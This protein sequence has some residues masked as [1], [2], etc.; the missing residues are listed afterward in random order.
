KSAMGIIMAVAS[1]CELM[2]LDEPYLGLDVEKRQVFYDVLREEH[3]RTIVISTHHLN[4]LSGHLDTVLLLNSME[5]GAVEEAN[6]GILE[7]S[8]AAGHADRLRNRLQVIPL[9][10][11]A[12][13]LGERVILDA[14]S[15]GP[16][17]AFDAAGD[18]D[19]RVQE[20]NL[21]RAV[22]AL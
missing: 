15:L 22:L 8:D 17:H 2:L 18:V 9:S 19:V 1:G 5:H 20:G 3:G 6:D 11:E 12:S 4:E 10:R 7:V 21:D 16:D 13:G 14:I